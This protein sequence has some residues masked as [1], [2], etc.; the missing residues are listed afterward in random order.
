MASRWLA[1][2]ESEDAAMAERSRKAYQ[3]DL[4]AEL[5]ERC[6]DTGW[7]EPWDL[8]RVVSWKSAIV[9]ASLSVV[10]PD[11]IRQTTAA[12][13]EALRPYRNAVAADVLF[14]SGDPNR[15]LVRD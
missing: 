9:G 14:D 4:P 7:I 6:W 5:A 11:A 15:F 8:L 2:V 12:V 10:E 1:Y 13:I 3:H